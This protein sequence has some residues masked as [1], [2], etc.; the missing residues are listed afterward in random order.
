VQ[1]HGGHEE[2][3]RCGQ[4]EVKQA[5]E[6]GQR[7]GHH[8]REHHASDLPREGSASPGVAV[9]ALRRGRLHPLRVVRLE[10]HVVVPNEKSIAQIDGKM[11]T[12]LSL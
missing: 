12:A 1:D 7:G 8:L 3:H 4:A 9:Q 6:D 11:H 5:H 10:Q 2:G